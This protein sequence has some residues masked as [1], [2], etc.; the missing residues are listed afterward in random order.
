[1]AQYPNKHFDLAIVDPPYGIGQNWKKDTLSQFYKHRSKYK[2]DLIPQEEYFNELFRVSDKQII[3]GGEL[4]YPVP[5]ADW[6]MDFLGQ[7]ADG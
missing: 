4:L 1:M 6:R 5:A 7:E 2:N 3:W